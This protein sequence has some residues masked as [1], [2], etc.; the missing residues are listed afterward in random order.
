[1]RFRERAGER[2]ERHAWAGVRLLP[3]ETPV[4]YAHLVIAFTDGD[5][6]GTAFLTDRRFLWR[7]PTGNEFDCEL[8]LCGGWAVREDRPGQVGLATGF[9]RKPGEEPAALLLF[10]QQPRS[11]ANRVLARQFFEAMIR[12]LGVVHPEWTIQ[13]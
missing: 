12:Q 10:P 3:G 2:R 1:M 8:E 11:A 5:Q 6:P 4:N 9:S 7:S 13:R